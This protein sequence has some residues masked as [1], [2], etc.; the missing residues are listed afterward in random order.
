MK[1]TELIG[2]L[3]ERLNLPLPGKDCQYQLAASDR[4][5]LINFPIPSEEKLR[6]AAVLILLYEKNNTPYTVL[7]KRPVYNGA[8]SGQIAFPGG[9]YEEKDT[10]L[11]ATALRESNEEIGLDTEQINII[12][13]LTPLYIPVSN[14]M[15]HPFVAYTKKPPSFSID[16]QEVEYTIEA[17]LKDFLNPSSLKS[18]Q[19][20][21]N[22][23]QITAPYFDV[24]KEMVWGA[25]AMIMNELLNILSN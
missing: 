21:L 6:K 5:G 14:I 20:I 22:N 8:H 2:K 10:D 15:V 23:M 3:S 19:L 24:N 25:T 7:I 13:K 1:L 11:Q 4:N 12:G 9:K 16:K 18:T 17:S